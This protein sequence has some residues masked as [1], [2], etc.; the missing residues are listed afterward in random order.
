MSRIVLFPVSGP[1]GDLQRRRV[2]HAAL[3][4]LCHVV[5][6]LQA[7]RVAAL[8]AE[9]GRVRVVGAAARAQHVARVERVGD[10]GRAAV[11]TR[12]TQVVQPLQVAALAL[13]VADRV[14]DELELRHV[15]EVGDGKDG[16]ED[17]L[18]ARFV[19]L[20]RQFVHLQEAVVRALLHLDE[21]GDLDGRRD[22][23]EI[24]TDAGGSVLVRHQRLLCCS[25]ELH[26]VKPSRGGFALGPRTLVRGLALKMQSRP[27]GQA[28]PWAP[29][30]ALTPT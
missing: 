6:Q 7:D 27:S 9:V 26:R 1:D 10:D 28:S 30:Q 21:V 4:A 20:A 24:E 19:A 25:P 11:L 2:G 17:G 22:L 14:I 8:V 23:A 12:R 16:L 18:Q 13:P 5:L 29:F 3:F 15:A